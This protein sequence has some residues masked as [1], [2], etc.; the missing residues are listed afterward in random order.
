MNPAPIAGTSSTSGTATGS[1]DPGTVGSGGPNTG[2]SSDSSDAFR[3]LLAPQPPGILS[4][5]GNGVITELPG[6]VGFGPAAGAAPGRPIL[7]AHRNVAD[8]DDPVDPLRRHRAALQSSE[9][10]APR[11]AASPSPVLPAAASLLQVDRARAALS[12]EDL[13]PVLVRRI[14]WSGDRERGTV[15]LEIGAGELAGATLLVLADAGRVQVHLHVPPGVDA[16]A[17]QA[18]IRRRLESRSIVA[19]AV[20]VS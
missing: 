5:S 10:L 4:A 15:R 7:R 18:R 19:D 14:A 13:V 2:S 1:M 9:L 11:A 3:A 20:E 6:S 16:T 12:L 17:W 8:D